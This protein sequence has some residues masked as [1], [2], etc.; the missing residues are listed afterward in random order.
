MLFMPKSLTH[1]FDLNARR[2]HARHRS[3]TVEDVNALNAKYLA[4]DAFP[5]P[6]PVWDAVERLRLVS[7][8]TDRELRE[9]TQWTHTLQVVEGMERDGVRD[10]LLYVAAWVHDLGKLLLLTSEDPANVVCDNYVVAGSARCGMDNCVVNW[11]H[12]EYVYLKLRPLLPPDILW[13]V[14]YHSVSVQACK[15]YFSDTDRALA[16]RLL[17]NFRKYDK[18]TK[19]L[20]HQPVVDL[21]RHRRLLEKF[22]P[23]PIRL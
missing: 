13:L 16:A 9:V 18:G 2:I 22:F 17:F 14:R 1:D 15:D 8:P 4:A 19:S 10:D 11:N 7:D 6:L 23:D 5:E 21:D 12:D 3:Q 20:T